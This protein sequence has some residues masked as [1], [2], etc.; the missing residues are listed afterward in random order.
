[1]LGIPGTCTFTNSSDESQCSSVCSYDSDQPEEGP[2]YSIIADDELQ[3]NLHD[4]VSVT[5]Q[6]DLVDLVTELDTQQCVQLP[7]SSNDDVALISGDAV[8]I[9]SYKLVGDNIDVSIKTRYNRG[10][11]LHNQ[12]LHYFHFLA[13]RDRINFNELSIVPKQLCLNKPPIITRELLPTTNSDSMIR[14]NF[15]IIV[16]RILSTYIPFFKFA[17]ADITTWHIDHEHY[18]EMSLKSKVV[19]LSYIVANCI[20]HRYYY[21][22]HWVF[23]YITRTRGMK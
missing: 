8:C 9:N 6:D 14:E 22:S 19:R 7:T 11:D 21:R 13:V 1:M 15:S 12:S 23:Y 3:D 17:A 5:S 20:C 18:A 10:N 16:S 2:A 4:D